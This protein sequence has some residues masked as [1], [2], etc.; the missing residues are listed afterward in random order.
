M[1]TAILRSTIA[2]T[3]MSYNTPHSAFSISF[4]LFYKLFFSM[5]FRE[6]NTDEYKS[7]LIKLVAKK[8]V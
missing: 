3:L 1:G 8:I 7:Q 5:V 6:T 2:N 4:Y